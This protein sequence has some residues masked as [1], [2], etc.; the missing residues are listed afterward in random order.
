MWFCA[1]LQPPPPLVKVLKA[2]RMANQSDD[3]VANKSSGNVT[4]KDQRAK[5][6]ENKAASTNEL[7]DSTLVRLLNIIDM[8]MC[9]HD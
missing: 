9:V 5:G 8:Y 4:K 6:K 7:L 1:S 3:S 2:N